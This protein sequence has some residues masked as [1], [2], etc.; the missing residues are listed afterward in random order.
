[1]KLGTGADANVINAKDLSE[2]KIFP[3]HIA[4]IVFGNNTV[5]PSGFAMLDYKIGARPWEKLK[6]SVVDSGLSIL[7]RLPSL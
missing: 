6:F 7:G 4:L 3:T 5:N 2:A 1:M